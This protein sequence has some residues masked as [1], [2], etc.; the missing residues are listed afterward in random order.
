[1]PYNGFGLD[2]G[3]WRAVDAFKQGSGMF[4]KGGERKNNGHRKDHLNGYS[5]NNGEGIWGIKISEF[6]SS[7]FLETCFPDQHFF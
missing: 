2:S 7:N 3:S 4:Q 1:M 6:I 5:N